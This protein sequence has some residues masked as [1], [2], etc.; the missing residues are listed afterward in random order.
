MTALPNSAVW[1]SASSTSNCQH[2][3]TAVSLLLKIH[4]MN[5]VVLPA[6]CITN[7][8][9]GFTHWKVLLFL[10]WGRNALN[11][12]PATRRF[13]APREVGHVWAFAGGGIGHILIAFMPAGK[14]EDFFREVTKA[15]AM[16]LLALA[17]WRAHGM[18]LLGPP[19]ALWLIT[20][21]TIAR[22]T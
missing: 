13:L 14:M 5:G 15:N 20:D 19:L 1:E 9:N 10:R 12:T 11:F 7:R 4:S 21:S 17:L 2:K 6:I 22:F 16:P 8:K 18:E 3:I